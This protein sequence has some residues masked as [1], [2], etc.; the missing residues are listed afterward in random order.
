MAIDEVEITPEMIEAGLDEWAVFDER[1]ESKER[2][3]ARIYQAMTTLKMSGLAREKLGPRE[4]AAK[5]T[6]KV[7][8][9]FSNPVPRR[10]NLLG[11]E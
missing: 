3:L 7:H 9:N 10:F 8:I 11:S 1:F 4:P 5:I 6:P 2:A